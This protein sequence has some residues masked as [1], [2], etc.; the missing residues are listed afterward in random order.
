[1]R[2]SEELSTLSRQQYEALQKAPYMRMSE[3]A[4]DAYD[5]R[6]IRIGELCG[7]L[8]KFS[9]DSDSDSERDEAMA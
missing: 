2:L 8:T 7:L 9:P 6:R 1:M 5:S 3:A 4:R